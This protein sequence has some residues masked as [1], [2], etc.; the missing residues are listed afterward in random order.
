MGRTEEFKL[1]PDPRLTS[2]IW[3]DYRDVAVLSVNKDLDNKFFQEYVT[4]SN[5]ETHLPRFIAGYRDMQ[6]NSILNGLN[7]NFD[8]IKNSLSK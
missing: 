5:L 3:K 4:K 8:D 7:C 2:K 1:K 6:Y